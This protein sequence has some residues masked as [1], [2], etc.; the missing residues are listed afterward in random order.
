VHYLSHYVGEVAV[1]QLAEEAWSSSGIIHPLFYV[2][3]P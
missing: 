1:A 2:F 3:Q